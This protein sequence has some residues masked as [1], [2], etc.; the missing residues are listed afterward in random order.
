MKNARTTEAAA[1]NEKRKNGSRRAPREP[2]VARHTRAIVRRVRHCGDAAGWPGRRTNPWFCRRPVARIVRRGDV[3]NGRA[4]NGQRQY[5]GTNDRV[6]GSRVFS[7]PGPFIVTPRALPF[8]PIPPPSGASVSCW[9]DTR[10]LPFIRRASP[11][12]SVILP[13]LETVGGVLSL[14]PFHATFADGVGSRAPQPTPR[15]IPD[16]ACPLSPDLAQSVIFLLEDTRV[17]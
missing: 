4:N 7:C 14:L 15:I 5:A 2:G 9:Q 16:R 11:L 12:L 10:V 1:R 6:G 13:R 3:D 8:V 17:L